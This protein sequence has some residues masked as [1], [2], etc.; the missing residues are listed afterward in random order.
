[1]WRKLLI[2]PPILLGVFVIWWFVGQRQPP[3]TS[4]P[5]EEI[6]NVRVIQA[7]RTDLIPMVSGF[8][9]VQPAKTWQAVV[10]AAGEVEYKHPRLMRGAIMPAGTEII[11]I[12]PRDYEL[13]IAQ[14]EANIGKADAQITEFDL[15]EENTRASLKIEREAL[16]ISERE[17]AR[18]EELVRGG[19]TS[20]TVL[21]QETRDTL[22]Q[23]KKVQDLENTLKL[24]PSQ[25]AA[26]V[27]QKKLN[28]I[29]LDQAK[30]N[31]TRTRIVLPFDAR[32]SEVSV[33]IAQYA[34]VGSVLVTADGIETAE[35]EAQVPLA[36]FSAL[37]R[38]TASGDSPVGITPE[39]ISDVVK[40]LGF[41][42]TIHL[43]AGETEIVW[44]A[45]F[46]RV[47][48]TIDLKTR[49][50]GAIVTAQDTWKTAKPGQRPPLS[51]GM[52][53][54]VRIRAGKLADQIVVPRSA[55]HGDSLYLADKD[56]RLVIKPVE[57]GL[58]QDGNVVIRSGVEPG[59]RIIVSDLLPA[60]EGMLLRITRDEALEAR[61]TR[62]L[63]DNVK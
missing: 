5:Q 40:R 6:R 3:Q 60:I 61:M 55:L 35:V 15:T 17:L 59:A 9:T 41:S 37:A 19:A 4:A 42:A 44:P 43:N 52:F 11:R 29:E 8:G 39:T 1:M 49:S 63:S 46:S 31:L 12:S 50:I 25:R 21:D 24:I 22:A 54:E 56:N 20:R 33:E 2:V 7:Q 36:Q 27:Q 53:V 48:D 62:R 18:K 13:A 10:Q 47:S 16:T 26:L 30:L 58:T 14:A 34:Q 38:A 51:K 28:Q 23:R 32:V 45:K 57:T